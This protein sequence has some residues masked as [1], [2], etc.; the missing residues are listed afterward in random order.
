MCY[1]RG[2]VVEQE[3]VDVVEDLGGAYVAPV[4]V[5]GDLQLKESN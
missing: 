1:L 4:L 2:L 3:S 5:A